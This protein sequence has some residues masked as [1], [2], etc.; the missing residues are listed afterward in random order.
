MSN[1]IIINQNES[2]PYSK[3]DMCSMCECSEY[4][5]KEFLAGMS[6]SLRKDE[7]FITKGRSHERL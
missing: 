6:S 5:W 1:V 4:L 2:Y 7:D 3:K